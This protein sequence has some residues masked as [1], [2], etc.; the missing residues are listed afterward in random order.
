MFSL[1]LSFLYYEFQIV[2]LD[3]ISGILYKKSELKPEPTELCVLLSL[4]E[5]IYNFMITVTSV[6]TLYTFINYLSNACLI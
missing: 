1:V 5:N 4:V 6:V 3:N 2:F